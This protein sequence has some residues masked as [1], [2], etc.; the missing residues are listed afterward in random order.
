MH[1]LSMQTPD[2]SYVAPG[3]RATHSHHLTNQ[4]KL[5]AASRQLLAEELSLHASIFVY[6]AEVL[7]SL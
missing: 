7:S 1:S 5:D 6:L 2:V 3:G 4:M